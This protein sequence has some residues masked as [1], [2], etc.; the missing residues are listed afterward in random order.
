[1]YLHVYDIIKLFYISDLCYTKYS[2]H[3]LWNLT[4]FNIT[5]NTLLFYVKVLH[6]E[7]RKFHRYIFENYLIFQKKIPKDLF[8]EST[9][10]K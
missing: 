1:M 6:L 9:I 5:K 7:F 4:F 3:E 10:L 2:L 8:S